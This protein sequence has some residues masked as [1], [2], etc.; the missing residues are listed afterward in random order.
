MNLRMKYKRIY[1][2]IR[3]IYLVI[4][5]L[6][7]AG[8]VRVAHL[9]FTHRSHNSNYIRNQLVYVSLLIELEELQC[10]EGDYE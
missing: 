10:K 6:V 3:C 9:Q 5:C 1:S 4:T 8:G 7:L 2:Q